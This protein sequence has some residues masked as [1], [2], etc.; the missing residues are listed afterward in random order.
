MIFGKNQ[1]LKALPYIFKAQ[2]AF[3]PKNAG[4]SLTPFKIIRAPFE[5]SSSREQDPVKTATMATPAFFPV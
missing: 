4:S 3:L 5:N 1:E 2:P